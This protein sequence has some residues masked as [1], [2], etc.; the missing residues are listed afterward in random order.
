MTHPQQTTREV[1]E[2]LV[3]ALEKDAARY[4]VA[5]RVIS[6]HDLYSAADSTE[7]YSRE[8]D[9]L[10]DRLMGSEA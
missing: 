2:Q 9:M 1:I 8:V 4:R 6:L 5:R 10:I 3:E 7:D